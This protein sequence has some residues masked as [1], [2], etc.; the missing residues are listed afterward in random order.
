MANP[1]GTITVIDADTDN[2]I[3]EGVL[4]ASM[5]IT[6]GINPSVIQM[7]VPPLVISGRIARVEWRY[8]GVLV[9][10]FSNCNISRYDPSIGSDGTITAQLAIF[11]RRWMWVS[12]NG[13]GYISG[14]YNLTRENDPIPDFEKSPKELAA[15]CLDAMNEDAFDVSALP[16]NDRP[17]VEWKVSNPSQMLA[18]ICD[19]YA[20][21]VSLD[22]DGDVL[23]VKKGEGEELPIGAL[24]KEATYEP[25]ELPKELRAVTAPVEFQVDLILEPVGFEKNSET[26][27]LKPIDDLTYSPTGTATNLGPSGN[28]VEPDNWIEAVSED[29]FD[30]L[31]D[32]EQKELAGEHAYR[33]WRITLDSNLTLENPVDP[34]DPDAEPGPNAVYKLTEINQLLPLINR[35]VQRIG[36]KFG[37]KHHDSFVWGSFRDG[38][39]YGQTQLAASSIGRDEFSPELKYEG[40]FRVDVER[41]LVFFSEPILIDNGEPEKRGVDGTDEFVVP[42]LYLRCT[43]NLRDKESRE[44]QRY[45]RSTDIDVDS[46]SGTEYIVRED[47]KYEFF[48]EFEVEEWKSNQIEVDEKLDFYIEQRLEQYKAFP[49]E[50]AQY[51]GFIAL[52]TDGAIKQVTY[53][54]A[55]NGAATTT[56]SRNRENLRKAISY[57]DARD[58]Q[59]LRDALLERERLKRRVEREG[60]EP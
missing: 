52:A 59:K 13:S 55:A 29:V 1:Q 18:E 50:E 16:D 38:E 34:P 20:C 41:G 24:L 46:V 6:N 19:L 33:T 49:G 9:R 32:K 27:R 47:V 51:P 44:A 5:T 23:I 12:G 39:P 36:G 8:D 54:I 28:N 2:V 60:D 56:V 14:E 40:S 30:W 48:K 22:L 26:D 35:L 57:K 31:S 45:F 4:S 21:E 43:V 10:S 11:D 25:Q 53:T 42:L 15:L 7:T 17:Y 58:K 37:Q 3:V